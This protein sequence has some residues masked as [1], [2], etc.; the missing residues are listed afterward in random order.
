MKFKKRRAAREKLIQIFYGW[1][2][3]KEPWDIFLDQGYQIHTT[4]VGATNEKMVKE[5][6]QFFRLHIDRIDVCIQKVSE[7]WKLERISPV[8][9]AIIRLGATELMIGK[10]PIPVVINEAVELAKIYGS[11]SSSSFINGILHSISESTCPE[12][13]SFVSP[14][15]NE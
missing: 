1:S 9:L 4:V 13:K 7:N 14:S 5:M 2:I 15:E 11:K 6:L 3:Q 8:D 10:T 12:S